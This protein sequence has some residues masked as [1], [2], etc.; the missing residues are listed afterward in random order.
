[1][2]FKWVTIRLNEKK[3]EQVLDRK[4]QNIKVGWNRLKEETLEYVCP[5]NVIC[6]TVPSYTC[7]SNCSNSNGQYLKANKM[8]CIVASRH[9]MNEIPAQSMQ[10]PRTRSLCSIFKRNCNCFHLKGICSLFYFKSQ[11][12][13]K[14]CSY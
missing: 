2:P 9:L 14:F 3:M 8:T 4:W 1:M 10:F 7:S 12:C 6:F 11:H 13:I 5:T